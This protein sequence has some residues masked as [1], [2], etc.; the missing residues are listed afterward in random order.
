MPLVPDGCRCAVALALDWD[1]DTCEHAGHPQ[2]LATIAEADF[3]RVQVFSPATGLPSRAEVLRGLQASG[4]P[5]DLSKGKMKLP[6][7]GVLTAKALKVYKGVVAQRMALLQQAPQEG[8][9]QGAHLADNPPP[10]QP[11][12]RGAGQ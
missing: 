12:S 4:H 5:V 2:R 10:R 6:A 9:R 7:S 3:A 11:G 8:V 1:G